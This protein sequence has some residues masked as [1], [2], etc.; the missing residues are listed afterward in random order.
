M[1]KTGELTKA[2]SLYSTP[3]FTG[4]FGYKLCL[5]LYL[6]GDGAGKGTHVS[7]FLTIMRGEYDALLRWP[8]QQMVT[9]M[10]LDQDKRKNFVQAF[11]SEPS[12]YS[13][14]QPKTEMNIASGCPKFAPLLVLSHPSYFRNDTLYLK[15]IVDKTALDQP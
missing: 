14:Q 10:L 12:S 11:C 5:Q 15:V 6:N 7:F 8:L 2:I 9:L 13:F 4:R 1:G 3:F